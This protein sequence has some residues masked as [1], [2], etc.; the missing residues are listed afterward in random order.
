M[1]KADLIKNSNFIYGY[2]ENYINKYFAEK[3]ELNFKEY[4]KEEVKNVSNMFENVSRWYSYKVLEMNYENL[5]KI[6]ATCNLLYCGKGYVSTDIKKSKEF[7]DEDI[8][9]SYIEKHIKFGEINEGNCILSL[10]KNIEKEITGVCEGYDNSK[11]DNEHIKKCKIHRLSLF[12]KMWMEKYMEAVK[13]FD[14]NENIGS[15]WKIDRGYEMDDFDYRNVVYDRFKL[16]NGGD[17]F[18]NNK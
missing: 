15:I 11:K 13:Y 18:S 14:D 16:F 12:I 5:R 4:T 7:S 3:I 6:N 2:I 1:T 8:D 10:F 17:L 9:K